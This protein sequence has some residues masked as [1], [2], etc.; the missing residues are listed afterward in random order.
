VPPTA[1]GR[2]LGHAARLVISSR[3]G[4]PLAERLAQSTGKHFLV[5]D[6][7]QRLPW[8]QEPVP[9]GTAT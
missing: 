5:L 2:R 6:P 7:L 1:F 4:S 3:A 8:Y 9:P